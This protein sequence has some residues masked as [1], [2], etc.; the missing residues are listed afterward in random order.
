M[1]FA[2]K[3]MGLDLISACWKVP[4][5]YRCTIPTVAQHATNVDGRHADFMY[6]ARQTHKLTARLS[7]KSVS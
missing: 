5:V 4:A 6:V 1:L 2:Y 7:A 3:L